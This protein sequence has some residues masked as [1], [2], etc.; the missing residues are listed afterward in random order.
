MTITRSTDAFAVLLP[1]GKNSKVN[2][3]Q[4]HMYMDSTVDI[5]IIAV[6][7]FPIQIAVLACVVHTAGGPHHQAGSLSCNQRHILPRR[8]PSQF[9]I[10]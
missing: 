2:D 10:T 5:V 9:P 8:S 1:M 6:C 4:A 7:H 3:W